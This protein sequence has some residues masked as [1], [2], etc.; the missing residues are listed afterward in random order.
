MK[1]AEIVQIGNSEDIL[2]SP[3]TEYVARFVENINR[4]K[5]LTA[6]SVMI[7][8]HAV[9]HPKDG[10]RT[11]LHL[12]ERQGISSVYVT[13]RNGGFLGYV[14]AEDA[15]D[16]AKAGERVLDGIIQ[17]DGPT[18]NLDTNL[19][20]L[21]DVLAHTKIPIAV[22]DEDNNLKGTLVRGSVIAGLAGERGRANG[23]HS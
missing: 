12:M 16:K 22:V 19:S 21:L 10:P 20:D 17:K 14:R 3:A 11:A 1:D 5:A 4:S 18:T 6:S 2:L 9:V 8:P 15:A 13:D 23:L 7:K